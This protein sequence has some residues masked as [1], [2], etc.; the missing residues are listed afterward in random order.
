MASNAAAPVVLKPLAGLTKASQFVS[1]YEPVQSSTNSATAEAPKLILVA[2][3]MDARDL[4]IAKYIARYQSLYP[5]SKILL[6]KF[7]FKH[8]VWRAECIK[9]IQPAISYLR[10]QVDSGYLSESPSRPE[11]LLHVFSNG[12]VAS[13][14]H[15]F[16]EYEKETGH[17]FPLHAAVYD[18]C[19]GLFSYWGAY[20]ASIAG[21][22]KGFWRWVMAPVIHLL[23]IYLWIMVK[24]F[25]QP[26]HLLINANWHNN[27]EKTRQTNRA[28]I[29][30]KGDEMVDWKH[31]DSHA[32]QAEGKGF[33]VRQEMFEGSTHVAHV[34]ADEGRY[35][36][37]V[38]ETWGK[39]AHT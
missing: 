33:V 25:R 15:L 12:G 36:R 34:R 27:P 7:I 10:S 39:A 28:Y 35:W 29:Y 1:F 23:D 21:V 38:T 16:E 22:P 8:I 9:A 11:V 18:S 3:W 5:T 2:S 31:V 17:V 20:N 14:K 26:Y 13:T 37:I 6:V 24:L 4:H 32:R 30:G 19:P